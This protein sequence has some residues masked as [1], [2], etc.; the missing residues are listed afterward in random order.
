MRTVPRRS[1]IALLAA[2][3]AAFAAPSVATAAQGPIIVKYAAGAD[4]QERSE[5]RDAAD[6]VRAAALPLAQTEVVAPEAGTSVSDAV[7]DLERSPDVAYA[8]PDSPRSAFATPPSDPS[9]GD[10]WALSNTGQ[11]IFFGSTSRDWYLGTP[12]DDIDVAPAW[13]LPIGDTPTVA[14]V[15]SGVDLEHP[16]LKANIVSGGK[17]FVDGDDVPQDQNGHGTHVAGTIGAVGNNGVGVTGVAG[18][19]HLLPV[20]VLNAS[21]SASVSTVIKGEQYAVA[22]GAKIVN[23]SLGGASPSQPEYDTLRAAENTL[24][25]VA[26][27]NDGANVDTTDSYPCAYDLP[28]VICVAATGG[29]DELASFSNYGADSVDIAAP[30]VDIL[31]TYPTALRSTRRGYE[32][33]SGTSMATPEVAGAAALLLGQDPALTPWQVRAKLMAGADP[34]EGLHGKVASGGRLDVFGAMN[35]AAPP[36]DGQPAAATLAPNPRPVATAPPA[37]TP[38]A[39]T[40]PAPYVPPT[41][42]TPSPAPTPAPAPAP[43]TADTTAPSVTPALAA[44]GALKLLLAGRLKASAAVSERA[45]VRFE[46]R[47]DGRTAKRLHIAKSTKAAVRIAAGTTTPTKP[48]TKTATL[49]L[50]SAARRAL[51]RL[52]HVKVTLRAT[53]TDAAGNARTRSRTVTIT[54]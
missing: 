41:A 51:A 21:G 13:D 19:A 3:A 9:F 54:R 18:T 45:T 35:V 4:A 20:R 48:G 15:D 25:V 17:D 31:S 27:G 53:A 2:V 44:R 11:Q 14:V 24:F 7:A 23:M 16:D 1:S 30:G 52:R 40:P 28:N 5:A 49:R 38:P 36:A 46:L 47:L 6:V 39:T 43:K 26:A 42:L 8:E 10:Q 34:V 32:W 50:T 22:A 12:G 33:L 37:T 29:H